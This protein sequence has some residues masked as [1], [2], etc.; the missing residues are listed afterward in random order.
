M[1]VSFKTNHARKPRKCPSCSYTPVAS[2]IYGMPSISDELFEKE[3]RGELIFGGCVIEENQPAWQ[4]L[5]CGAEF[6]KST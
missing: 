2:I 6:Y 3:K 5:K 1:S 4:C